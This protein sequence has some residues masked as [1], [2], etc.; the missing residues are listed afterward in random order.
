[1]AVTVFRILY[2]DDDC[3]D[4]F[5]LRDLIQEKS[6]S[7]F[8]DPEVHYSEKITDINGIKFSDFDVIISDLHIGPHGPQEVATFWSECDTGDAT[9]IAFS[10]NINTT[11]KNSPFDYVID[12]GAGFDFLLKMLHF[13]S[14]LIGK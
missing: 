6:S 1:M 10:G 13:E 5:N 12:K 8:I 2:V 11:I 7:F 3:D 4:V 9:L 14:K